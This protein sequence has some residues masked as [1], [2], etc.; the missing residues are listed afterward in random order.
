MYGIWYMVGGMCYV[1]REMWCVVCGMWYVDSNYAVCGICCKLWQ[2]V[3]G[4]LLCVWWYGLV[5]GTVCQVCYKVNQV[6]EM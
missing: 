2:P 4:M 1:A 5:C 3:F 6:A